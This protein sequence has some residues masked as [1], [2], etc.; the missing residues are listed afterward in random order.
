M[1]T[2]SA[3]HSHHHL[4]RLVLLLLVVIP[5]LPEIVISATAAFARLMGCLPDQ[6]EACR[7]GPV[8][9]SDVINWALH[10]KASWVASEARL[11]DFYLAIAGWMVLCYAAL[12]LG[13]ARVSSR[14]LLGFAVALVFAL[15]PYFVPILTIA[16]LLSQASCEPTGGGKCQVYGGT[17]RGV[18]AAIRMARWD[19]VFDGILL[20]LGMFVAY[21]VVVALAGVVAARRPAKPEQSYS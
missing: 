6:K 14:L 5:F 18:A 17:V 15:L 8:A 13:W 11:E 2:T 20:A 7:I 9:V 1:T 3:K 16:D 19:T 10:A 21:A 4:A 12:T